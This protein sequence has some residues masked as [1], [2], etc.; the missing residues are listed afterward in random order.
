[1][2][3]RLLGGLAAV[4][5]ALLIGAGFAPP[6]LAF[7]FS[8]CDQAEAAGAAPIYAGE[9][10]YSS[11]LDADG[12]G[13][14]CEQGSGGS[15]G[16]A[17]PL[18]SGRYV[19][20]VVWSDTPCVEVVVPNY[21]EMLHQNLCDADQGGQFFHTAGPGQLVGGDP[22]MG[23]ASSMACSVMAPDGTVIFEDA[24]VAGDGADVNC[25]ITV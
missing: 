14:A 17:M 10:G 25:I 2:T 4:C 8:N 13:V 9:P 11:D 15:R 16:P 7:P 23:A 19:T 18:V 21:N 3:A 22:I 1:M 5:T 12:D 6:A 20:T 24:G